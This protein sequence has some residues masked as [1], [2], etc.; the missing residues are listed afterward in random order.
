MSTIEKE[1]NQIVEDQADLGEEEPDN[2]TE[3]KTD[4]KTE[5]KKG[6]LVV[7]NFQL[8]QNCKP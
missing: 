5:P 2:K 1:D 6:R 3:P 7:Q 4:I 8:A